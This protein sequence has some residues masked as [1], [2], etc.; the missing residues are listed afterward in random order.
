M[1]SLPLFALHSTPKSDRCVLWLAS[2]NE[3]CK[4]T[5][6]FKVTKLKNYAYFAKKR[7]KPISA[8]E[9]KMVDKIKSGTFNVDFVFNF[10][11]VIG[12][13]FQTNINNRKLLMSPYSPQYF[14]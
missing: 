1:K 13:F 8:F 12:H 14:A 2:W 11:C 6:I 7:F 9:S 3:K 5:P 10:F 4:A